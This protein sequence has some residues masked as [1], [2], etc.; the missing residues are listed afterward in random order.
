MG[1]EHY[2]DPIV[3]V[4]VEK[5]GGRSTRQTL[6]EHYG[7]K[8]V[9]LYRV[10]SD[11]VSP[12]SKNARMR[13]ELGKLSRKKTVKPLLNIGDALVRAAEISSGPHSLESLPDD[14]KVIAGH[15]T[16][17]RISKVLPIEKHR[18]ISVVREP[19]E[20][21]RSHFEHWKETRGNADFRV[22]VPYDSSTGFEAFAL[23]PEMQNYQLAA[24]GAGLEQYH[25]L[26]VTAELDGFLEE[27]GVL[28]DGN[29]SPK[30]GVAKYE[31]PEYD[32]VFLANFEEFHALDYALYADVASDWD[33]EI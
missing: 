22:R 31:R 9:L 30:I 3:F 23:L 10:G 32:P 19:L 29:R 28:S 1:Q 15:F 17:D 21:M 13:R 11:T 4:H 7:G 25:L 26:G 5:A 18:Y 16:M 27:L 12:A 24:I 8:D 33:V 6:I 20:R 14:F 2:N